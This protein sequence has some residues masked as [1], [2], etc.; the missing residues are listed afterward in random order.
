MRSVVYCIVFFLGAGSVANAQSAGRI[1]LSD[2]LAAPFSFF[3]ASSDVVGFKDCPEGFQLVND[4]ALISSFGQFTIL[5]GDP[6]RALDARV[7]TLHK[8]CLPVFEYGLRRD[9]IDY[10]FQV[11]GMPLKQD[12]REDL[13]AYV[14]VT[15]SNT[16]REAAQA[17]LQAEFGPLRLAGHKLFPCTSWYRDRFME[18]ADFKADATAQVADYQ[19]AKA[20]HLVF[21]CSGDCRPSATADGVAYNTKLLPGQKQSITFKVPY[22]PVAEA[23]ADEIAQVLQLDA[24]TARWATEV[25]WED[26]L[27]QAINIDLP[28]AKVVDTVRAS[29]AYLLCARDIDDTGR[30][31]VQKVNEFQYDDFF[32]RDS[33]YIIRTYDMYGLHGIARE[34]LESFLVRGEDGGVQRFLRMKQ[35]PDDWGQ[36]LWALGSHYRL[37]GETSFAREVFPGIAPHLGDL[38][39]SLKSDPK[40]LWP[41]APPYD[42]EMI[43]GHYTGHN[44]WVALGLREAE[45]LARA[46]GDMTSASRAARLR[47][48]FLPVLMKRM[49]EMT[50]RTEGYIPPGL[51]DPEAGYDWENA[52]GGVYPFGVLEADHPWAKATVDTAREYKWREGISTWGRNAWHLKLNAG[53]GVEADPGTIH[54]YETFNVT[55]T[56]L[57]MGRQREV[58]EDLYSVLAHTSSTHAGF[59]MGMKAWGDRDPGGNYPPHGWFAARY[60][61]LLRNMLLRE[62]GDDLHVASALSPRW[63]RPGDVIRVTAAPTGFGHLSMEIR[64]RA[65][66]AEITLAADWRTPPASIILHIPWFTVVESAEVDGQVVGVKDGKIRL[67]ASARRCTLKWHW[68]ERPDLSYERAVFLWL[69]KN[70][71]SRP[72]TDRGFL[73]PRPTR[74]KM[75]DAHR[76]FTDRYMVNLL[77][78]TPSAEV[79]FTLDGSA[80]TTESP[81]Y[82]GPVTIRETTTVK[83]IEIW[84]GGRMSE[85]LQATIRK[86]PYHAADIPLDRDGEL[87]HGVEMSVYD[88]AFKALPDFAK[89]EPSRRSRVAEIDLAATQKKNEYAAH[90]VGFLRVPAD[91]V[92]TVTVGSDDGS[93]FSIGNEA[94]VSNDGLHTYTEVSSE[95]ALKAGFHAISLGYF[96]AGGAASLR[97]FWQG[98]DLARQQLPAEAV[99]RKKGM[100]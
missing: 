32:P 17:Q 60:C 73:F 89:T 35:H 30:R 93:R 94:L 19:V 21:A 57:A 14:E 49:E 97:L 90:W 65:D 46:A 58:L 38:E 76:I 71:D 48:A 56:M 12:P 44:F 79:R 4:G 69:S 7:K 74:P 45:N 28:E 18:A 82:E 13:I 95:V 29:L 75:G 2:E 34:T 67:P 68:Q 10:F 40:G 42:N 62:E 9:G 20:G 50:G 39:E 6:P 80:P 77:S 27:G 87:E 59:E 84:P 99:F 100:E 66:G 36:S 78:P 83:A 26:L 64:S 92:Y 37:T 86:V 70:Y 85:P 61:E 51:D 53:Q 96:D 8:G 25:F 88:G 54:H 5:V 81:R 41:V 98:P 72:E 33:A 91:G 1:S 63:V 16:G 31:F 15:M 22:V 23:K 43:D 52:S 3:L 11:C 47:E 55:E 24:A